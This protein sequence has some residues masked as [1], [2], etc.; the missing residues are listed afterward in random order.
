VTLLASHCFF[1]AV[2]TLIAP[3]FGGNLT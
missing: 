1:I 2:G 3:S